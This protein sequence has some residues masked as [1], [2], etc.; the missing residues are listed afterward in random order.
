M[1]A[2]G[3]SIKIIGV[4][5]GHFDEPGQPKRQGAVWTVGLRKGDERLQ[6]IAVKA[7]IHDDA[8]AETRRDQEYQAQCA[9][10][11]VY[12]LLQEGWSP[13]QAREH[14]IY[15]GN[16]SGSEPSLAS[17]PAAK[18]QKPWWRLW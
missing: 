2:D 13:G 7:L 11:Y 3:W 10:H 4:I 15:I 12:G 14:T 17:A 6:K 8:T 18:S 1:S 5:A 9:M 16:P